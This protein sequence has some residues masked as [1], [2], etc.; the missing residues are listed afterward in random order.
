MAK[1]IDITDK[2]SMDEKPMIVI[3]GEEFEVNASAENVLLIMGDFANKSSTDAALSAYE[4]MF[5][6]KDRER[7]AKMK[8]SFRDLMIVIENSI[9]L[10]TGE[11][12]LGKGQIHTT[13]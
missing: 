13:T 10:I 3:Q 5:S 8:L 7:L 6:E 11:D 12:E 4:R 9:D 2:L 1:K